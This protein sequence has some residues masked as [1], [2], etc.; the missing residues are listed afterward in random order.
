LRDLFPIYINI[1]SQFF[2]KSKF[3][4][5]S[6]GAAKQLPST[7]FSAVDIPLWNL[8]I[9]SVILHMG[10]LAMLKFL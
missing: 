9:Y 6:R 1:I 10:K 3:T 4:Q 2:S 8:S 7:H 5:A